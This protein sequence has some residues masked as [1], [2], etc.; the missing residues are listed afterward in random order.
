M[1]YIHSAQ[2]SCTITSIGVN[3]S[4]LR[5]LLLLHFHILPRRGWQD[6]LWSTYHSFRPSLLFDWYSGKIRSFPDSF[7]HL[8]T[9]QTQLCNK[10]TYLHSL[11]PDSRAYPS[12]PYHNRC[13]YVALI[14]CVSCIHV[15]P[16]RRWRFQYLFSWH[17]HSPS[18]NPQ[19]CLTRPCQAHAVLPLNVTLI[20]GTEL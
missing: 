16:H 19:Q 2:L 3:L 4:I 9:R 14:S 10:T 13:T 17:R 11:A 1:L 20:Q 7:S 15:W 6:T 18:R 12:N 5:S 8:W